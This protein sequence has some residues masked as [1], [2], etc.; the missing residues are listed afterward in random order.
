MELLKYTYVSYVQTYFNN[1][2][3]YITYIHYTWFNKAE[4][5]YKLCFICNCFNL[6][7]LTSKTE[8]VNVKLIRLL[9]EFPDEN[10]IEIN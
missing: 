6:L 9:I 5:C 4:D 3:Y 2:I 10:N 7:L 1:Y 8:E